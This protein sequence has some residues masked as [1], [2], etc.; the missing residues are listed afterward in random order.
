MVAVV[1]TGATA[2]ASSTGCLLMIAIKVGVPERKGPWYSVL[3]PCFR[4]TSKLP[5][6][7]AQPEGANYLHFEANYQDQ[8]A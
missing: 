8:N 7:L 5:L 6:R 2:G 1:N 4:K 3:N